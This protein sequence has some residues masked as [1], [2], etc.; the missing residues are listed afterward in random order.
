MLTPTTDTQP[1]PRRYSTAF[2]H[3]LADSLAHLR[4]PRL[5][6]LASPTAYVA[7]QHLHPQSNTLL[8]EYDARFDVLPGSGFVKWDLFDPDRLPE[9]A[10]GT[11][12]LAVVDPPYLNEVRPLSL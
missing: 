8:L 3:R 2:A 11:V 9:S 7:F 12:E 10:R 4:S 1:C 5:A 6:F